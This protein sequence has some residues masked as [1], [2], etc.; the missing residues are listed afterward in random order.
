MFW[1]EKGEIQNLHT[2]LRVLRD[3]RNFRKELLKGPFLESI[4]DVYK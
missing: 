1:R 4:G 3:I 2:L